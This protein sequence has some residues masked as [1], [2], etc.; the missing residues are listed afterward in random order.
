MRPGGIDLATMKDDALNKGD[1]VHAPGE[2][3]DALEDSEALAWASMGLW[4][5]VSM[6]SHPEV[7]ESIS[8][9]LKE[10]EESVRESQRI[11]HFALYIL[12]GSLALAAVIVALI[13]SHPPKYIADILSTLLGS[14][15]GLFFTSV[16]ASF[17][18][19]F[20]KRRKLREEELVRRVISHEL[21]YKKRLYERETQK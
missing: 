6:R 3:Q 13:F 1:D 14:F 11:F 16:A 7:L 4:T 2:T 15:V 5:D 17:G 18:F 21:N 8:E 10:E 9:A 20:S 12:A 19:G